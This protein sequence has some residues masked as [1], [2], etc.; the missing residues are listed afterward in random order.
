M[1]MNIGRIRMIFYQLLNPT[2]HCQ[3]Q[4]RPEIVLLE[5]A[6]LSVFPDSPSHVNPNSRT[7]DSK[8]I[9]VLSLSTNCANTQLHFN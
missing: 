7:Q 6:R 2:G 5:E 4:E 1:N 3:G 8:I 9:T